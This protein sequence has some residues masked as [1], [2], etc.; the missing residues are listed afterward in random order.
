MAE[1]FKSLRCYLELVLVSPDRKHAFTVPPQQSVNTYSYKGTCCHQFLALLGGRIETRDNA[2]SRWV[3]SGAISMRLSVRATRHA[4]NGG[5]ILRLI[6]VSE[7]FINCLTIPASSTCI[8]N[9]PEIF[10]L[11]LLTWRCLIALHALNSQHKF[12]RI[13]YT[14]SPPLLW[15][16]KKEWYKTNK[17]CGSSRDSFDWPS[18]LLSNGEG[19][20]NSRS[21]WEA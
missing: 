18:D 9:F 12:M 2:L 8:E 4:A 15:A 20:R 14:Y 21:E 3:L 17:Y 10:S 5:R 13:M 6:A 16:V 1:R 19:E 7:S 11:R